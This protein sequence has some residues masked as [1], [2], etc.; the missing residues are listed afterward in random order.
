[1]S[2]WLGK[3]LFPFP[4]GVDKSRLVLLPPFAGEG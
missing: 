1:M 4:P 2:A 3:G